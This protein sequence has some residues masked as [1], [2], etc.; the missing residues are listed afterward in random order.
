MT[1][2]H[3]IT[4]AVTQAA[5]NKAIN[6]AINTIRKNG[7]AWNELVQST[8]VAIMEHAQT[9]NDC[10][11]A[12]RLLTAMPKSAK[13]SLVALHFQRY[14]PINVRIEKNAY[15]AS[16]HQADSKKYNTFNI[17]GAEANPWYDMPEAD[18]EIVYFTSGSVISRLHAIVSSADSAIKSGKIVETDKDKLLANIEAVKAFAKSLEAAPFTVSDDLNDDLSEGVAPLKAIAA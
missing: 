9:H 10:T 7:A 15:K 13:R 8:I 18:K 11:A 3:N 5:S 12:E 14:S 4:V 16:Y 1:N 6:Q 2:T 17:G